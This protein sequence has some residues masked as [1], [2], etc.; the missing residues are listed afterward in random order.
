MYRLTPGVQE[1]HQNRKL[2]FGDESAHLPERFLLQLPDGLSGHVQHSTDLLEIQARRAIEA[3]SKPEH[4]ALSVGEMSQEAIEQPLKFLQV[5]VALGPSG[6]WCRDVGAH[7]LCIRRVAARRV[8][9]DSVEKNDEE[10]LNRLWA[11]AHTL[12]QL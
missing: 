4:S 10:L 3:E 2:F 12:R 7:W 8:K 6:A 11:S 9:R 1:S 5:L